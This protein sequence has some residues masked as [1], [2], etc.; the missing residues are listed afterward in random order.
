MRLPL[1]IENNKAPGTNAPAT[2][3]EEPVQITTKNNKKVAQGKRLADYNL[4]EKE[5]LAQVAKAQESEPNLSQAYI[6]SLL[7]NLH[8]SIT[9]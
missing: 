2:K 1:K 4:R 5:R 9:K 7:H 8:S 3:V 6:N